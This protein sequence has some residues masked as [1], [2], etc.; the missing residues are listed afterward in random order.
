MGIE[1]IVGGALGLGGALLSS[2]AQ[3]AG[4]EAISS[5]GTAE[6]QA[7]LQ[8]NQNTIAYL[9]QQAALNRQ[10]LTQAVRQAELYAETYFPS[11][12]ATY[13]QGL[14]NALTSLGDYT[15]RAADAMRQAEQTA[16]ARYEP[17]AAVGPQAVQTL[18]DWTYNPSNY[19][20]SP[21]YEWLSE[22][23]TKAIDRT[24]SAAGRWSS[25]GTGQALI[26][27]SQGLASQDY[28]NALARVNTLANIGQTAAGSQASANM[29]AGGNL[30]N[31]WGQAGTNASNLQATGAANEANALNNLWQQLGAN[32]LTGATGQAASNTSA[33]NQYV[34]A[35]N[36]Y[37]NALNN[38]YNTQA[39][40]AIYGANATTN[41][42]NSLSSLASNLLGG[43]YA[44]SNTSSNPY[45][46]YYTNPW[47]MSLYG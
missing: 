38:A 25:P 24:A 22:Q 40:G 45:S 20:Q 5:A 39:T 10:A 42:A 30:M 8:S 19:T 34:G 26:D 31:L 21:G 12:Q 14:Q 2:S 9:E 18:A 43:S 44:N 37:M 11:V 35:Q 28:N 15:N 17:Y 7:A 1:T 32:V 16:V 46:S 27:Y 6:A 23:G 3:Q 41:T 47:G 13:R 29:T 36:T 4:A 33:G